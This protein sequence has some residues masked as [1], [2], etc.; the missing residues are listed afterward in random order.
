MFWIKWASFDITAA[1][2]TEVLDLLK[3]TDLKPGSKYDRMYPGVIA[4]ITDVY[5][6]AAAYEPEIAEFTKRYWRDLL[7]FYK[8][9]LPFVSFSP[10]EAESLSELIGKILETFN[11]DGFDK[12]LAQRFKTM[13]DDDGVKALNY[14][15]N[16]DHWYYLYN[17]LSSFTVEELL[18]DKV[19]EKQVSLREVRNHSSNIN[20]DLMSELRH[21]YNMRD[22]IER[23]RLTF[24]FGPEERPINEI[25]RVREAVREKAEYDNLKAKV[26]E[27]TDAGEEIWEGKPIYD[28]GNGWAIWDI[29]TEKDLKLEGQLA[30]HCVG[31]S[32]YCF[33]VAFGKTRVVSLRDKHQIPWATIELTPD[34]EG[35]HQA[36]GRHDHAIKK[37]HQDMIAKWLTETTEAGEN[38]PYM[39]KK[40]EGDRTG[41]YPYADYEAKEPVDITIN[42]DYIISI[43]L[44]SIADYSSLFDKIDN[45]NID[46]IFKRNGENYISMY[47][48]DFDKYFQKAKEQYP[49]LTKSMVDRGYVNIA[50]GSGY[51]VNGQNDFK[52]LF[53]E[54]IAIIDSHTPRD[55]NGRLSAITYPEALKQWMIYLGRGFLIWNY[56]DRTSGSPRE[57]LRT[58]VEEV[59]KNT[60]GNE[61]TVYFTYALYDYFSYLHGKYAVSMLIADEKRYNYFEKFLN[62][63]DNSSLNRGTALGVEPSADVSPG[64]DRLSP[65][66]LTYILEL[67][68]A[69]KLI[70]AKEALV[71]FSDIGHLNY[72]DDSMVSR[73]ISIIE[74]SVDMGGGREFFYQQQQLPVENAQWSRD[75]GHVYNL[76]SEIESEI[77]K[78]LGLEI[79][80]YDDLDQETFFN[81]S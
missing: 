11:I 74:K 57:Y 41:M 15:D 43:N 50:L 26:K 31:G 30:S 58:M 35:I 27:K 72:Y 76:I 20:Y 36:F 47:D 60:I 75:M 65:E 80:A 4:K 73:W 12:D 61:Y 8:K 56:I 44:E 66:N 81:W 62:N 22:E 52:D 49:Q 38:H 18:L 37:E 55:Q 70:D 5:E 78:R 64:Q 25:S 51:D 16:A 14:Y 10:E 19:S 34:L 24:D 42:A 13:I 79:G 39:T 71:Q 17:I 63:A 21:L 53:W 7:K 69:E 45:E 68:K 3:S 67:L 28:F 23:Y 77:K 48:A 32:D 6:T 59:K 9:K 46:D 29:P 33:Y 40:P 54:A 2:A 1:T